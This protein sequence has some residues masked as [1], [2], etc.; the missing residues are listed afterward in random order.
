[1]ITSAVTG[2]LAGLLMG[3]VLQ[4]GQ[5]CFHSAIRNSLDG[6]FLLARGWALGVALA[7]GGSHCCSSCPEPAGSTRAWP[8][9]RSPTWRVD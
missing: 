1:M 8:F 4:R 9:D 5:L 2:A 7:S 3:Y 6:R